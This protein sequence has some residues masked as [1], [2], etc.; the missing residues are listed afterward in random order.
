MT[1]QRLRILVLSPNPPE[2]VTNG[3][4]P[5]VKKFVSHLARSSDVTL[6]HW[7][8]ELEV[9]APVEP[10]DSIRRI[11]CAPPPPPIGRGPRSARQRLR[12]GWPYPVLSGM[13]L[14]V[15]ELCLK[16][17][18]DACLA[19]HPALL[20]PA[21]ELAKLPVVADL[22]DEPVSAAWRDLLTVRGAALK[23]RHLRL[24]MQ[25]VRYLRTYCPR[26]SACCVVSEAEAR[27]LRRLA[28]ATRVEV[29]PSGV[30]TEHFCPSAE[31]PEP[32]SLLFVGNLSFPP[33]QAAVLFF[34]RRVLPHLERLVPDFRWFVVGPS[35]SCEVTALASDPRIVVTGYV[36]DIRPYLRRC[37]VFVSPLVSGGGI[38]T[39]VLEAWAMAKPVVA[40]TLGSAGLA[41]RPDFNLVVA[42]NPE[43][44][45][46]AVAELFSDPERAQRIGLAGRETVLERFSW[47]QHAA[48]LE[49]LL[50]Q[51]A[52]VARSA[53]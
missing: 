40:T 38:K 18:F 15:R 45:A 2:A 6:V 51:A 53:D 11:P 16:Q 23:L 52:G 35:P 29:V 41:A 26:A 8:S 31:S 10:L 36:N 42:T 24:I 48:H 17:S 47:H 43:M 20:R 9:A 49:E 30:D 28:P 34:A 32:R 33:N 50:F 3:I 22:I 37:M 4:S 39:K 46:R 1:E 44:I 27:G 7:A 12:L 5:R 25:L 21:L 19:F 13:Q 14:A